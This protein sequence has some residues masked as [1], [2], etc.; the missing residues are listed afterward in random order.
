MS[1][2][3][4]TINSPADLKK[5][6]EEQLVALAAEVRQFLL[7]T[8]SVT[9]GHLASNLGCVELTLAIH[10]C[11]NSPEDRIIWDVGHQ[12]YTH[13][14]VTGRRDKFHTQRQY[15]GISGFPKRSESPH[16]PFGAGH[17]STSISAGLGMAAGN[18]LK[19][20]ENRAI[21]VIGD[22]S[23]TAGMAFEALNQA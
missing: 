2:L 12:A 14:I 3:L 5:L 13:K 1:K 9:G 10:Y 11:F 20:S 16:D 21:A 8:V 15:Q 7:E 18:D 22:G 19:G 17:S 23:M 4:E 6:T